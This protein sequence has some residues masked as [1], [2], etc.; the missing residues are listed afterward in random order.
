MADWK[1]HLERW[2]SAGLIDPATAER[3]REYEAQH[4]HAARNGVSWPVIVAVTFG[5]VML[6]AGVLLFVAA[7]WEE[8]SPQS[9]FALVLAMVAAFHLAGAW[10]A[11]KQE[12]LSS[13]LHGVGTAALGGGIFLAGQIFN[14]E[15]HWPSGVLL[16]GIGAVAGWL[17]LRDPVQG[18][19]AAI[20]IPW[21]LLGEWDVRVV[22]K[23]HQ[24]LTIAAAFILL[25]SIAYFGAV[26][27]KVNSGLRRA[28]MWVGG[29]AFI[30]SVIFLT[31]AAHED[32]LG[33]RWWG[34]SVEP[35][36]AKIVVLGCAI[37]FLLPT[38][39]GWFLRRKDVLVRIASAVWVAGIAAVSMRGDIEENP[40][41]FLWCMVGAIGMIAWGVR[42][43]R[44]ER[45]N[46]G[47]A[48][49]ALTVLGFYF[50]SVLDKFGR[51][52]ALIS[53]GL[54]FLVGGWYLERT[55]RKL[56]AR[57]SD[58]SAI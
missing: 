4:P 48:S 36:P 50:S 22:D 32:A 55:R 9:R 19:M 37:A 25:T 44:K 2:T 23:Y 49:F 3:V 29:L 43:A 40:I 42:E 38:V 57:I 27:G 7:H 28:L 41:Y 5:C 8:L 26:Q 20:L 17:L 52:T 10:F 21:W 12:F 33:W 34:R 11:E 35:V 47:M 31:V 51:S 45:I 18:A 30:P 15:E 54:I 6:G 58:G 53:M 16:W 1:E 46:L 13:A 14:L 24:G 39:A 56:I